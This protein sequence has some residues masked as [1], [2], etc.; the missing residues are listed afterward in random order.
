MSRVKELYRDF[1]TAEIEQE[2]LDIKD[3]M[4]KDFIVGNNDFIDWVKETFIKNREE[5][6][7]IPILRQLKERITPE[8]IKKRTEREVNDKKLARKIGI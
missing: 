5:D 7:E 2:T 6:E 3:I 8:E 4:K 1:L